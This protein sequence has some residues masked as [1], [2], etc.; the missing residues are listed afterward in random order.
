[1]GIV[2]DINYNYQDLTFTDEVD[3]KKDKFQIHTLNIPLYL[4][5]RTGRLTSKTRTVL[6]LGYFFSIPISAKSIDLKRR[7]EIVETSQVNNGQGFSLIIGQEVSLSRL[8]DRNYEKTCTEGIRTFLYGKL[9]F[10][11]QSLFN[12]NSINIQKSALGSTEFND[13]SLTLGVRALFGL[14]KC[15]N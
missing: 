8:L 6:M 10:R 12:I 5:Y 3:N 1:M 11:S 4:K 14:S 2:G 13:Y 9:N 15:K 7:T